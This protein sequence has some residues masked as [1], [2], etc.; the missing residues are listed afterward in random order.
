MEVASITIALISVTCGSIA[1]AI[2]VYHGFCMTQEVKPRNE[3]LV[4]LFPFL[5]G[6]APGLLTEKGEFHRSK[7]NQALLVA[8]VSFTGVLL[9]AL[10]TD[11]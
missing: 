1:I 7:F 11:A 6:A 3:W 5:L 8:L 4:N 9:A 10:L 2:A